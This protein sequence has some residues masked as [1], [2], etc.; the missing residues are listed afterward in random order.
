MGILEKWF[1]G[2]I[3]YYPGCLIKFVA[4]DLNENY[5]KILSKIGID[6]ILL[7]DSEMCCGNPIL[8]AGHKEEAIE[9]ANKNF[10]IFKE[11]G[12]SKIITPCPACYNMFNKIYPTLVEKWDIKVEHVT[13]TIS[14]AI[15]EGKISPKNLGVDITYHDPCH[16]GRYAGVYEEPRNIV[17]EA[18]S[19][20]EMKLSKNYSFCC[21]GGSGVKTNQPELS[22]SIAKQRIEMAKETNAQILCTSCPMCYLHLKEN[23]KDLK[24]MELSQFFDLE[25]KDGTN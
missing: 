13:Q 25:K 22:S 2:N 16:L 18:G 3:L 1:G 24:V 4:K 10:K 9:L 15:K 14:K 19:L 6:Y 7:S 21:G 20:K 23:S 8:N 5:K 12:V 17:K 11:R